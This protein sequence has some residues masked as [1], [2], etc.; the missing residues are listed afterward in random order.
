[1]IAARYVLGIDTAGRHGS[2]ALAADGRALV[3]EPLPPGGH[4]SGLSDAAE[5]L[6]RMPDIRWKDLAGIAVSEGPGSFT[7]LRIGL[8]WAKGFCLGSG[9][10]LTLVS[11]HEAAAYAHKGGG[12][13]IATVLP[14]ER[15]EAQMAIW[16]AGSLL[17]GPEAV[18][19][20]DLPA[21]LRHAGNGTLR[22]AAPNPRPETLELLRREGIAVLDPEI[23]ILGAA[24]VAELGDVKLRSGASADLIRSAPAY[25]RAPNAR[26]PGS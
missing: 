10:R 24:A 21:A 5:S 23:P 8:A 14:G 20:E 22:V 25:G 9:I 7:G 19:E 1:M 26:K 16:S 11:G 4:S 17:R 12:L 6:L 18:K 3:S 15:G 2:I 13:T